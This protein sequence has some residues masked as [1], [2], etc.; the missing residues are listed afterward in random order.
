MNG[1]RYRKK[2]IVLINLLL[3]QGVLMAF[4]II[5][6]WPQFSYRAVIPA[7]YN[8][9]V[10][11]VVSVLVMAISAV[12]VS[13]ILRLAEKENDAEL[14]ALRLLESEQM[15]HVLRSHRHDFLNHIQVIY[16][17][18]RIGKI[19]SLAEYIG[20]LACGVEDESKLSCLA[21]PELAALLI[22]KAH[23]ASEKGINL[24]VEVN[25]DL[26]AVA[27]PAVALVRLIGNLVDNALYAVDKYNLNGKKVLVTLAEEPGRF[28]FSVSNNGPA[29]AD[30]L[31]EKIFEKGFSTKGQEGSGLGLY[32]CRELAEKHGGKISL[33]S[34]PEFPTSFVVTLP[35]GAKK[36]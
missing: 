10:T 13:E 31:K 7:F 20:E 35:N 19:D 29:I 26:G 14:N 6:T 1:I 34:T 2:T 32:I 12:L 36:K 25:T 21:Q 3:L 15:I 22:K 33:T 4:N 11:I 18:A 30:E 23:T 5:A 9:K 28:V 16:G 17:L 24:K 8:G 27:V